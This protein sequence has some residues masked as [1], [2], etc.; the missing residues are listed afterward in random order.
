MSSRVLVVR[1][2]LA[3]IFG[4]K[5]LDCCVAHRLGLLLPVLN[6]S[7]VNHGYNAARLTT[8]L[9]AFGTGFPR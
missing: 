2:K 1:T 9:D 6:S 5:E 3:V 7:C 4:W 8:A